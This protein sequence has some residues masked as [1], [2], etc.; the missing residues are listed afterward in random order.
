MKLRSVLEPREAS[1][2]ELGREILPTIHGHFAVKKLEIEP[3][4]FASSNH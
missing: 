1:L 3:L 4:A 2:G